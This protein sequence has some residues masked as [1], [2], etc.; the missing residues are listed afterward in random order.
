VAGDILGVALTAMA[1]REAGLLEACREWR[2]S[3]LGVEEKGEGEG[4][5][6]GRFI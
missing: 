1:G 3:L 5:Q 4:E 2:R 6:E